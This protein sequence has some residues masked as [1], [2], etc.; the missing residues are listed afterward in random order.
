[1]NAMGPLNAIYFARGPLRS[2]FD[3]CQKNE[4]YFLNKPLFP[5][6]P[7]PLEGF[8]IAQSKF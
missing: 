8:K 3:Q 2:Y 4:I 7:K 1:M 5:C 6:F